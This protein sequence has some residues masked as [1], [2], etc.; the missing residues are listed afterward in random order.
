MVGKRPHRLKKAKLCKKKQQEVHSSSSDSDEDYLDRLSERQKRKKRNRMK[1]TRLKFAK[2][3]DQAC[4]E[5]KKMNGDT[6]RS[7]SDKAKNQQA[8]SASLRLKALLPGLSHIGVNLGYSLL[9]FKKPPEGKRYIQGRRQRVEL[10]NNSPTLYTLTCI[11]MAK[12]ERLMQNQGPVRLDRDLRGIKVE[13]Q[14]L[15]L[16][17]ASHL[18]WICIVSN[19]HVSGVSLISHEDIVG[20]GISPKVAMTEE[21]DIDKSVLPLMISEVKKWDNAISKAR[22]ALIQSILACNGSQPLSSVGSGSAAAFS[23]VASSGVCISQNPQSPQNLDK[24]DNC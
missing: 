20:W 5:W 3:R 4:N 9:K 18:Y 6:H 14:T 15:C 1:L 23:T 2:K 21:G 19:Q 22:P 17:R 11:L 13:P 10:H 24:V 16:A 8:Q 7:R 12:Q